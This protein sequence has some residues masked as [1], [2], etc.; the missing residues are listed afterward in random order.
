MVVNLNEIAREIT[1][2]EGGKQSLSI[3]QIKEVMR[4]LMGI[5]ADMSIAELAEFIQKAK[6]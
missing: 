5:I 4:I 6:R 1:L 2:K 3:A